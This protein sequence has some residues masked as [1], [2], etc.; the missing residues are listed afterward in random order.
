[1]LKKEKIVAIKIF[2]NFDLFR[3]YVL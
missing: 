2:Y 1:L 3:E